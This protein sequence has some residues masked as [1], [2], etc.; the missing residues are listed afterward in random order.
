MRLKKKIRPAGPSHLS[1]TCDLIV[2]SYLTPL[3]IA[4]Y[5]AYW[6]TASELL[7]TYG[8]LIIGHFEMPAT[9]ELRDLLAA[10][11]NLSLAKVVRFAVALGVPS[12]VVDESKQTHPSDVYLVKYDIL[13]WWIDNAE[14]DTWEAI[15]T[16]LESAGVDERNLAKQIR[17]DHGVHDGKLRNQRVSTTAYNVPQYKSTFLTT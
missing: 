1:R 8:G 5:D 16:A 4:I 12:R 9:P 2:T 3:Y 6:Y 17:S 15:A 10:V 11:A 7:F 14:E 13:R